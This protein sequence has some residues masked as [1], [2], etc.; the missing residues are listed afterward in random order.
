M[1]E[2]WGRE[3]NGNGGTRSLGRSSSVRMGMGMGMG[4]S[5]E[6]E[7][8]RERERDSAAHPPTGSIKAFEVLGGPRITSEN[9]KGVERLTGAFFPLPCHRRAQDLTELTTLLPSHAQAS[10]T[11]KSV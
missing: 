8:Q 2:V 9:R 5:A 10:A 6:E 1:D 3:G 11:P 4:R 7:Q